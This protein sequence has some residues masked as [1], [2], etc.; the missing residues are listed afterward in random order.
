MC[1]CCLT[2]HSRF[3][4]IRYD[5]DDDCDDDDDDC[6]DCD[7]DDDCDEVC[8]ALERYAYLNFYSASSL[9]QQSAGK[10]VA[11][12]E[13]TNHVPSQPAFLLLLITEEKQ[14]IP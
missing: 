5:D 9:K 14:Q 8:F 13:N 3:S 4:P 12:H 7:D 2:L 6:D 10:Y 1:A 11:P